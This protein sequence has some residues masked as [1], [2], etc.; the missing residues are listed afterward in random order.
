VLSTVALIAGGNYVFGMVPTAFRER[1]E[2]V[3]RHLFFIGFAIKTSPE[4]TIYNFFPLRSGNGSFLQKRIPSVMSIP[5]VYPCLLGVIQP[6]LSFYFSEM[7]GVSFVA[8]PLILDNPLSIFVVPI[9]IVF[10]EVFRATASTRLHVV[11]NSALIFLVPCGA[12]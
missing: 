11:G 6:L 10:P 1:D 2:V 9:F 7:F 5:I 8:I 4:V 3:H 12:P